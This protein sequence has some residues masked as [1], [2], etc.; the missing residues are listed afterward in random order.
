MRFTLQPP[1]GS[2]RGLVREVRCGG[3]SVPG[4]RPGSTDSLRVSMRVGTAGAAQRERGAKRAQSR[5]TGPGCACAH[6]KIWTA[7][8]GESSPQIPVSTACYTGVMEPSPSRR[9]R[10]TCTAARVQERALATS[11]ARP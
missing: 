9:L 6:G 11:Q 10:V 8:Q 3:R 4:S 7:T 1:G 5:A 2:G